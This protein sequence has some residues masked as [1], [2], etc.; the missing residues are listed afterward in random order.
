MAELVTIARPYAAAAFSYAKAKGQLAH[1]SD[2]LAFL[3]AVHQNEQMQVAL[4]NPQLTKAD[5][6]RMLLAVCGEKIDGAARNLLSL[7]ARNNRLDALPAIAELYE[8]LKAEEES[9][10]EARIESAFP[11]SDQQLGTI[12]QRLEARVERKIKPTVSVVPELIGGVRVQVGDD[13][14]DASVRGQLETLASALM[15]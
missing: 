5:A 4:D 6:E 8:Q 2:M 9:L 14:W 1:W 11:M 10:V 3:V 7:L 13:V 15:R 12:V